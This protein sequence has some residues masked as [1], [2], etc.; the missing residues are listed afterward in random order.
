[1]AEAEWPQQHLLGMSKGWLY[2]VARGNR[3]TRTSIG[4][5]ARSTESTAKLVREQLHRARPNTDSTDSGAGPKTDRAKA[6]N[7]K[8]LTVLPQ[9]TIEL[10]KKAVEA[11]EQAGRSRLKSPHTLTL[12]LTSARTK[13]VA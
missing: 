10:Q 1:M 9:L 7:Q 3:Q 11:G 8:T 6:A 2:H 12:A 4:R 13:I 5:I